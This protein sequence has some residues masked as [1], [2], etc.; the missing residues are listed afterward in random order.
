M[1]SFEIN[2]DL[3]DGIKDLEC[4]EMISLLINT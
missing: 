3:N 2:D 1:N 4:D